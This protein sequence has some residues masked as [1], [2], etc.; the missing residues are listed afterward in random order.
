MRRW[1]DLRDPEALEPQFELPGWI[2]AAPF[3]RLCG[4]EIVEAK[5]GTAVLRM[6]FKVK[7]AQG[8]GL[9]HG[10]ALTT[11][12][13]TAV[14]MAIKSLVPEGTHFVTTELGLEFHAPVRKGTV[15]ARAEVKR[16]EERDIEGEA[17]LYDEAGVHVA[18]FH[19][20]FRIPRR[21][22]L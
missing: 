8:K 1:E 10:G 14:A 18:T 12:A 4:I 22:S 13:D 6:P 11:L 20:T 2:A 15:E 3:E 17:K 16:F 5:D 7:L 19:S 9:L 21:R